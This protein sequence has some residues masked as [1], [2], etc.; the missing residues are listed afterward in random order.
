MS[1]CLTREPVIP[2]PYV[3]EEKQLVIKNRTSGDEEVFN[4][5]NMS[6]EEIDKLVEERLKKF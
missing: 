6:D 1:D 3:I 5:D 2:Q 4:I